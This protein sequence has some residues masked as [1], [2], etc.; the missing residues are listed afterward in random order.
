[1]FNFIVHSLQPFSLVEQPVFLGL[2]QDLQPNYTI[3]SRT[4]VRHKLDKATLAMKKQVKEA[5]RKIPYIATTTDC[6]T[7]RRRS[8]IGV[9]A[10][11]L[12]PSSFERHSVGLVCRPLKGS[13]TFDAL[14]SAMS[15]IHS[16]NEICEKRVRTITDNG[17]NFIKA[18]RVFGED[19]N[20]NVTAEEVTDEDP[21]QDDQDQDEEVE[22]TAV[23]TLVSEDDGPQHQLPKH[24]LSGS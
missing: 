5:M 8:S 1:M 21:T 14:A 11:W 4:T 18:F 23:G 13:H 9:T 6:W 17:S 16:E 10:H 3:M 7:A 15:D 19:E 24:H 2:V 20:N 22:F 12:D